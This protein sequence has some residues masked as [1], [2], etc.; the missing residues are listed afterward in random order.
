M[1]DPKKEQARELTELP[2]VDPAALEEAARRF[3]SAK[4]PPGG[5]NQGAKQKK[6]PRGRNEG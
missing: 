3:I 2:P 1:A 6:K 4:K 5:W